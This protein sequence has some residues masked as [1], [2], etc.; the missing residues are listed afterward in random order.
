MMGQSN[1]VA[2]TSFNRGSSGR[3]HRGSDMEQEDRISSLP[4]SIL[5]HILSFL[6]M[7]DAVKTVLHRRF[8]NLW[9]SI[10]NLEFDARSYNNFSVG[11]H[12]VWFV[13]FV[14]HVLLL[15]ECPT[16]F[17]FS[18]KFGSFLYFA[19]NDMRP[20]RRLKPL[21]HEFADYINS[22]IHFA[23]RKKVKVL[24]LGI[25]A[26]GSSSSRFDYDL[27]SIV[28]TSDSVTELKLVNIGLR[29]QGVIH[30]RLLKTL[31]L[32][33]IMLNDTVFEEILS[34]CPLLESLFIIQC[35]GLHKLNCTST[36][37]KN[38]LVVLGE[39]E[40]SRLEISGPNLLSLHISG[41][42]GRVDLKNLSSLIEATLDLCFGGTGPDD[43]DYYNV[44]MLLEKLHHANVFTI[45]N[46]CILVLTSW[47][48][49][50]VPCPSSSRKCL[51]LKTMLT[52]WHIHGIT[53]LLRSSP[54]LEMLDIYVEPGTSILST[55]DNL[56]LGLPGNHD[57]NYWNDKFWFK[58]PD[59]DEVNY[60]NSQQPFSCL[61]NHL[62]TVKISG[63]ISNSY[64]I[65]LVK[66][67]LRSAI[68]LEKLV[69]ST[70]W[71]AQPNLQNHSLSKQLLE[72]SQ[73]L[74]G[75]PKASSSAVI[76]FS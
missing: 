27:P 15:H 21:R 18:L 53:S 66:F 46:W 17:R 69:I 45:C 43:N 76:V 71:Y 9:T 38:L 74:S 70:K 32:T 54:N 72:F 49:R 30:M 10:Q 75:F 11:C 36:S 47:E 34:G 24:E 51:V 73:K 7:K 19:P 22:W 55:A 60:W 33:T 52:K 59:F 4:D 35:Y 6:P 65:Q 42:K 1:D 50:N 8:G 5:L 64:V 39:Y 37:L 23:V 44:G 41:L 58:S 25:L 48:F 12:N 63:C 3:K 40:L 26:H 61:R 14:N 29:H 13:N 67:L 16:I 31:S 56:Q 2:E 57:E 20:P 28:F 68:V 62:K